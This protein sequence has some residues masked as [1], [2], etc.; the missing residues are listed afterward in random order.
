MS[1]CRDLLFNVMEHRF[2]IREIADFLDENDQSFLGFEFF[3]DR[4]VIEKFQQRFP[5]P[6]AMTNL[7][8][9]RTFEADHP[10]TFW[11]MYLFLLRK[12]VP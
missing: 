12:N 7:D 5:E 8:H 6:A 4:A 3:D 10:Q 9:W 1:G 11:G 2:T